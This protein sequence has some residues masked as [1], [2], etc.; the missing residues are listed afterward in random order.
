MV[1]TDMSSQNLYFLPSGTTEEFNVVIEIPY[2]SQNKYELDEETGAIFLD[3]VLY[4]ATFYPV[5][6]GFIPSTK[7]ED[8]DAVDVLVF[9]N[10]PVPP[11]TVIKCRAVGMIEITDSGNKD[12]KIIAVPLDDP[13]Y[14]HMQDIEDV[15]QHKIKEIYDF[16]ANMQKFK[17]GEWKKDINVI[18]GVFGKAKAVDELAKY[19]NNYTK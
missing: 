5:N 10:N 2:G 17:N 15:P 9:I 18:D 3:R 13:H 14:S 6:Y 1:E 16:F 8:G 11:C 19:L 7:A 12:S 4:G